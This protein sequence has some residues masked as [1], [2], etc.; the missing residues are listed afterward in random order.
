MTINL[1]DKA[2]DQVTGFEGVCV[3]RTVWLHGCV[4][5]TLQPQS[6][7]KDGKMQ[8]AVTFDELQVDLVERATVKAT[9]EVKRPTS[10]GGPR[11]E[12]QRRK[13]VR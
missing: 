4:R 3:A 10:T 12:P 13:D 2:R 11:P 8:E 9:P 7:D 5:I 6:L 1:G